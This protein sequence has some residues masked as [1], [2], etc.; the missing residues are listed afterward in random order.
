MRRLQFLPLTILVGVTIA[1]CHPQKCL[2]HDMVLDIEDMR[3]VPFDELLNNVKTSNLVFVGEIHDSKEHHENQLRIIRGLNDSGTRI[4]LGLEMFR[5]DRQDV[6]DRW[7][8][9]E[10]TVE[11]FRNAFYERWELPW[12]LYA[13]IFLYARE[14][15]I[16]MVGLNVPEEITKKVSENGF[17]SLTREDLKKL[18]I[19]ISCDVDETYMDYIKRAYRAHGKNG[20]EFVHFCEAQLIWD[21]VMAWHLVDYL[22]KNPGTTVVVLAGTVHAWKKG[23][24]EQ[25]K[26]QSSLSYKVILPWNAETNSEF[27]GPGYAD[28]YLN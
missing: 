18:P 9:G 25:I 23:I 19:G 16:P 2:G 26:K 27:I 13:D 10:I 17:S 20:K 7:I 24:P 8:N 15:R 12:S 6:L 21:K 1:F 4:A 28:Y 3:V 22:R 14:N 5:A 11:E